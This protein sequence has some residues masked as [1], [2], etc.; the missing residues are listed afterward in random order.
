[1]T[2]VARRSHLFLDADAGRDGALVVEW[3]GR[4]IP[5]FIVEGELFWGREHLPDIREKLATLARKRM[6]LAY[7]LRGISLW[8][9]MIVLAV[10]MGYR[11]TVGK[12]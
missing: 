2:A 8:R 12:F 5:S 3:D 10:R 4:R 6:V 1:V 11:S 7:G 9:R